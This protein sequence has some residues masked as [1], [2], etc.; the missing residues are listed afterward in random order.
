MNNSGDLSAAEIF[1][2]LCESMA[3]YAKCRQITEVSV[4]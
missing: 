2:Y 1:V 4:H 3:D